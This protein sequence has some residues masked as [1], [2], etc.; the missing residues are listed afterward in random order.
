ML[1]AYVKHLDNTTNDKTPDDKKKL[2]EHIANCKLQLAAAE[3]M[4]SESHIHAE[5]SIDA[6]IGL[7]PGAAVAV[8]AGLNSLNGSQTAYIAIQAL[9]DI[10]KGSFAKL[11][12]GL[13]AGNPILLFTMIGI[14]L[15][16]VGMVAGIM[17]AAEVASQITEKPKALEYLKTTVQLRRKKLCRPQ[18]PKPQGNYSVLTTIIRVLD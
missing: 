6:A 17:P 16:L 15:G 18:R 1:E 5:R 8:L 12:E 13:A 10:A 3:V 7:V 14:G 11:H 2:K 9:S 4:C